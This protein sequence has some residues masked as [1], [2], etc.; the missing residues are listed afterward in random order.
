MSCRHTNR[1][2]FVSYNGYLQ[3]F[4]SIFYLD[5]GY[6]KIYLKIIKNL[7]FPGDKESDRVK[8]NVCDYKR[9]IQRS[10]W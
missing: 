6:V 3:N 2:F 5:W 4:N 8:R 9:A 10:L 1:P 7:V